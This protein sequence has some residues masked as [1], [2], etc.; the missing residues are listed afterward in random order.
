MVISSLLPF[1]YR[2]TSDQLAG[3]HSPSQAEAKLEPGMKNR[4][5]RL[6]LNAEPMIA[7]DR[8][9]RRVRKVYLPSQH[10]FVRGS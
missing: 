10:I 6:S 4:L 5:L 2:L 1:I 3:E 7:G 9:L 8:E